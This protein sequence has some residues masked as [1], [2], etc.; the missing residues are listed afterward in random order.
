MQLD[1]LANEVAQ[2]AGLYYELYSRL[3]SARVEDWIETVPP[4]EAELIRREAQHDFDYS[5]GTEIMA[6]APVQREF[7]QREPLFN[8]AW[9]MDY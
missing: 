1:A 6:R 8:P 9:D 4:S 5:M 7:S 2:P 3:F